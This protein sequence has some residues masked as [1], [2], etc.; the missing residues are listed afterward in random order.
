MFDHLSTVMKDFLE[1]GSF[2]LVVK[3]VA[4]EDIIVVMH[5]FMV[6]M[7]HLFPYVDPH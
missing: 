2:H 4:I 5:E 7:Y 6:R 3:A 1:I